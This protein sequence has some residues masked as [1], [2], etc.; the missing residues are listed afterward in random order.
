[1]IKNRPIPLTLACAILA[2]LSVVV[3]IGSA[4]GYPLDGSAYTGIRRLDGYLFSLQTPSG[5]KNLP[6]GAEL[7]LDQVYPQLTGVSVPIPP[8]DPKLTRNIRALLDQYSS[9]YSIAVLDYSDASSLRYAELNS[10]RRFVPGSVGKVLVAVAIFQTLAELFPNDIEKREK[11]LRQ[12][13]ITANQLVETDSHEVP[14]WH[15][16]QGRIELRPL[17]VGDRANL[18]SYLDWMLSASSNAAASIVMEQLLLLN[19]YGRY[20]QPDSPEQAQ[21]LSRSSKAEL[22]DAFQN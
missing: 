19:R 12:S 14:F 22:A 21:Y 20:Y 3:F 2:A 8:I 6:S 5:R 7:A 9:A 10:S 1:M 18:W 16:E 13:M 17:R 15:A 11:L 4:Q